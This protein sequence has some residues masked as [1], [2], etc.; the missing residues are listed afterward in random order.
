MK[1]S[2]LSAG[3][4]TIS[5]ASLFAFNRP[6]SAAIVGKISPQ[7]G[8][9]SVWAVSG[10]DSVR[11]ALAAGSFSVPVKNGIYKVVVDAKDPYKDVLLDNVEVKQDRP[12]DVGEIVLQQK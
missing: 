3:L 7:D 5:I 9:V 6:Q 12:V 4:I 1:R 2:N 8:A 11:G 10:T